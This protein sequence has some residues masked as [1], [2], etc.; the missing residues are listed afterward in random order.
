MTLKEEGLTFREISKQLGVSLGLVHKDFE[1]SL[2]RVLEPSVTAYRAEHVA[3]L[4][5]MREV[6]E[7]VLQRRHVIVSASGRIAYDDDGP[8][9]D[10]GVVL[11][12][13]DR[14]HKIDEAERKLLGLDV[15]PEVQIT[16]TLAYE[17]TGLGSGDGSAS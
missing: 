1:A 8:V 5:K 6:V 7:D 4:H 13:I 15:R 16:G 10:D 11:S 2:T 14:L 17:I 9:E 3:R 12:A